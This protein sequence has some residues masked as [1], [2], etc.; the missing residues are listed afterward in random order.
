MSKDEIKKGT[1][2]VELG[3]AE[4]YTID[5]K[6][7]V[8]R[9][10]LLD[11]SGSDGYF[12]NSP[13][14]EYG[15]LFATASAGSTGANI[16]PDSAYMPA[17]GLVFY[18]AGIAVITASVFT[19]AGDG[20]L[21]ANGVGTSHMFGPTHDAESVKAVLT[22]S[23]ISGA[24]DNFRNRLYNIQFNNTIELNSSIYFCRVKNNEYNYSANPTY[25][26]ES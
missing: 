20:G 7:H 17:A 2:Q 6:T 14:G 21:L 8:Q 19:D 24:C 16:M 13:A 12:V 5:G 22:G 4:N 18:Q 15:V 9:I 10:K 11:Y 26:S 3:V 25:R 23:N 1:F